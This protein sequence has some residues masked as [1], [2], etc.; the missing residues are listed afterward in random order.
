M[1][2]RERVLGGGVLR[3]LFNEMYIHRFRRIFSRPN[4]ITESREFVHVVKLPSVFRGKKK[5]FNFQFPSKIPHS[6][7]Y[8]A[9]D[10]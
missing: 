4:H 6:T 8:L 2:L 10:R 5:L 7:T 1:C 3:T 9:I